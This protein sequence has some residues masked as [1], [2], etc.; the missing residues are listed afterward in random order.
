[1]DAHPHMPRALCFLM[2]MY[3]ST[4]QYHCITSACNKYIYLSI[5]LSMHRFMCAYRCICACVCVYFAYENLYT[6]LPLYISLC[7]HACICKCIR[8]CMLCLHAYDACRAATHTY[9][10]R[11]YVSI[12]KNKAAQKQEIKRLLYNHIYDYRCINNKQINRCGSLN[13]GAYY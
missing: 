12:Q 8:R 2:S 11:L 4:R 9:I 7:M 13:P 3:D 1:M 10:H 5:Y 6:S